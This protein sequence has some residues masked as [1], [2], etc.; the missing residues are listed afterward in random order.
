MHSSLLPRYPRVN[1]LIGRFAVSLYAS[2][3]YRHCQ[4]NHAKHHRYPYQKQDPD[5]HHGYPHPIRWYVRFIYTY[6]PS[7]EF[8]RFFISGGM[9]FF[10]L[11]TVAQ[12][13]P[14]NLLL[15]WILPL[16]LSSI[17]LFFFGTYLPHRD[18]ELIRSSHYPVCWSLLT[19]YHFGYHEEHHCFPQIP[20][21]KLPALYRSSQKKIQ[22]DRQT[23]KHTA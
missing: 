3:S 23:T 2:L 18:R 8:P 13:S 12:V 22:E 9:I 17:Q 10:V 4:I 7:S 21:Y 14:I 6:L 5:F 19:C 16:L 20:W 15:F 1:N 11:S